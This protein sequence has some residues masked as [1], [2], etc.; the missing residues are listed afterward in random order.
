MKATTTS[1]NLMEVASLGELAA[2]RGTT[3]ETI[4]Y[5]ETIG[6]LPSPARIAGNQRAYAM[7]LPIR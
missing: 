2:T 7:V 1:L 3:I 5:H 6:L 4:R